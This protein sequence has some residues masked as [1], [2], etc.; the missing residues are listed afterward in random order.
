MV[1]TTEQRIESLAKAR[2]AKKLKSDAKKQEKRDNP[3]LKGRP[4]KVKEVKEVE[5]VKQVKEV[6]EDMKVKEEPEIEEQIIY[7]KIAKPKKKIVRKIIQQYE[8]SSSEEEEEI[9]YVKPR[10]EP[11]ISSRI[12]R[13]ERD[14]EPPRVR[15]RDPEPIA[16]KR[17]IFFSY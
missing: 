17:N 14:P 13:P 12:E 7:Q 1:Y 11:K 6:K 8:S 9:V 3:P 16:P 5:E 10:R 15:E 2:E 4:K